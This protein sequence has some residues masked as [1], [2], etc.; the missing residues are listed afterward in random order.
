VATWR[1]LSDENRRAA[2][3]LRNKEH[4]MFRASVS[5]AYYATYHAVTHQLFSSGVSDFGVMSGKPRRNPDH[6][7]LAKLAWRN[8]GG[9]SP[10]NRRELRTAVSR[11]RERR[12]DADYRPGSTIDRQ[13][14][15]ESLRDMDYA[16]RILSSSREGNR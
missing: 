10:H 16:L 7:K 4:G 1:E 6:D 12:I 3:M 9:L 11:L 13:I 14:M 2:V 8:L 15:I 5:R